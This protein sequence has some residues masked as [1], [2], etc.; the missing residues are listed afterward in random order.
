NSEI[1]TTIRAIP[2]RHTFMIADACFSG[3]LFG[4]NRS[5]FAR[6]DL[7]AYHRKVGSIP[8]RWGLASGRNEVVADGIP[9]ENSPFTQNLLYF[10][11]TKHEAPFAVSELVQYVKTATANNSEQTPIGSPLRNVGDRGGE[12]VFYPK[13]VTKTE[14]TVAPPPK[15]VVDI[16][17]VMPAH[18][19]PVFQAGKEKTSSSDNPFLQWMKDHFRALLMIA[20]STFFFGMWSEVLYWIVPATCLGLMASEVIFRLKGRGKIIFT[21]IVVILVGADFIWYEWEALTEGGKMAE[22]AIGS[23]GSRM[24]NHELIWFSLGLA[25]FA[26]FLYF[27]FTE[28][29]RAEVR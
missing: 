25:G 14:P 12:L 29:G 17:P 20:V 23:V 19:Q 7:S 15:P 10:L 6:T 22:D 9:G 4:E 2:S 8:S 3:S 1:S 18:A 16:P 28:Q 27:F 21:A 24:K 5:A 11:K 13:G 26:S